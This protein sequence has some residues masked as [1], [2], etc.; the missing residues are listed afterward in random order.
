MQKEKYSFIFRGLRSPSRRSLTVWYPAA[1]PT[2]AQCKSSSN[3]RASVRH[4]SPASR[5]KATYTY[6]L[7]S[8][9]A[10]L[11]PGDPSISRNVSISFVAFFWTALQDFPPD[12]LCE[13]QT[14]VCTTGGGLGSVFTGFSLE[15][16]L[17]QH[18]F[19]LQQS[20]YLLY[21]NNNAWTFMEFVEAVSAWAALSVWA[22]KWMSC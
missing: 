6:F 9:A 22:N 11:Q 5:S 2:R 8:R 13:T 12:S 10:Q 4:W 21:N 19:S 20:F 3:R 16:A 18:S 15:P 7:K 14:C 1:F 17:C